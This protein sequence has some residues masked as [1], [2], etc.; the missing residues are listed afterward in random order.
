MALGEFSTNSNKYGALGHGGRIAIDGAIVDGALLLR[1][2]ETPTRPIDGH[3]RTG[4][5]GLK[6]I[7]RT[8]EA[9][10]GQLA[11]D[12]RDDGLDIAI[13]LPGFPT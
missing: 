1:W 2:K 6:L 10:G 5:S 12:W 9:H 7:R 4:S 3:E 13:T 11:V 8:I